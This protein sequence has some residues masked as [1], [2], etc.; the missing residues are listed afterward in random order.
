MTHDLSGRVFLVTGATEGIGKAATR[1]FA[2]RGA[3][4]TL[5]GRDRGKTERVLAELE[6]ENGNKHLDFLIGDLSRLADV[7]RIADEFKAKHNG[8]DPLSE[9]VN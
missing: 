8:V 7:R 5:I 2:R 6:A 9:T 1:E 3:C 4:I